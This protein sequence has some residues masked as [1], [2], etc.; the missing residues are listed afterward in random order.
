[1]LRDWLGGE[2]LPIRATSG[3]VGV[4]SVALATADGHLEIR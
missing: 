3:A 2:D 4:R 1:M